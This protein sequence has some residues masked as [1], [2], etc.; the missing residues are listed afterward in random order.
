MFLHL[1][2]NL[3]KM[4]SGKMTLEFFFQLFPNPVTDGHYR[5]SISLDQADDV[6]V[7]VYDL[8]QQL[9]KSFKASGQKK[10]NFQGYISGAAGPYTVRLSTSQKTYS[11]ILIVQ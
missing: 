11:R 6:Q 1:A 4:L 8:N 5:I 9:I 7:Q 10:Y 3:R 2:G